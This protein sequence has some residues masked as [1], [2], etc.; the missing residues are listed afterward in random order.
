[1]GVTVI[2]VNWNGGEMLQRCLLSLR[3]SKAS[4]PIEVIVV[5]NA[6]TDGS[7]ESAE[8]GF[9]E[10]KIVNSGSNLGFGRANNL[11]RPMV[12]TPFVL[13]LNPD[14]EVRPDTLQKSV[15]EL[16]SRPEVGALGC[17]MFYPNGQ[18]QE[19]GIQWFP[20]P[21]TFL[22]E[23][24]LV[25][26]STFKLTKRWLPRLDPNCSG[27]AKKLYG[28]FVLI[29]KEVVDSAGWFDDRYFMYAEDVDLSRTVISLGW[30]LYYTTETNIM[31]VAGGTTAKAPGGFAVLMKNESILKYMKK[32]YGA[33]GAA[34]YRVEV[35]IAAIIRF[36]TLLSLR[37]VLRRKADGSLDKQVLLMKWAFGLRKPEIAK[38]RQPSTVLQ[39]V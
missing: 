18:I 22:L 9:P 30:K 15:D 29:R 8:V 27:Y 13:F 24:L 28:G 1:M 36:I 35:C 31:H 14:T 32:Y 2:I 34:L 26:R 23:Q 4:F 17:K 16:V 33:G 38:N 11:A 20:S 10:F 37:L 39:P 3:G 25:S 7:R 19:Q 12:K 21:W 5:D 6:S